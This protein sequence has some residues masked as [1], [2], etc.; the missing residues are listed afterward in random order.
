MITTQS[1]DSWISQFG[2]TATPRWGWLGGV[3]LA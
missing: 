3:A 2:V 1:L